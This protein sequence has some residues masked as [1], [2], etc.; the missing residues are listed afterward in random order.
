MRFPIAALI[1]GL[2]FL[3]GML[4]ANAEV[5]QYLKPKI[6]GYR[7]DWCYKW[8]IQCGEAAADR[9]CKSR[10][11][12]QSVSFAIAEDIGATN[13]TKVMGTGQICEDPFCDGFSKISCEREDEE[14]VEEEVETKFFK[15]PLMGGVQVNICLT[16]GSQCGGNA[17]AKKFCNKN[18][19]TKAISFAQTQPFTPLIPTRYIGNGLLCKD[20]ICVGLKNLTCSD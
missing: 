15:K 19:F 3:G 16:K 10:G 7:L 14:D 13:P 9:F 8:G 2:T 6:D 17:A 20:L 4:P 12:E 11:F 1:M 5:K 18:G